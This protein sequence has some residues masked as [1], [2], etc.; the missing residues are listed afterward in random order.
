MRKTRW[1]RVIGFVAAASM[2]VFGAGSIAH[3]RSAGQPAH[4]TSITLQLKW[5]NQAQFAGY[6]V[7][8]DKGFFRQQGLDVTIR[9]GGPDVVPEQVVASGAAQF[10]I[11]WLSALL[12]AREKGIPIQNIAQ[13][14]QASGMRL[15]AFK[16]SHIRTIQDFKGKR[17][18]VWP[19]GNEYQF[20]ALMNKYHLS[21]PQHYMTVTNQPFVMTPFLSHQIDVAHA[22]T[23]NEIGVVLESGIKRSA[24][25]IFDY[26]KLGVSILEDGIFGN[27]SYLRGHRAI[28]ARFL[29]AAME[30]WRYAVAHP[31]EAGQISYRHSPGSPGGE[32]HQLF[33]AREVAKLIHYG[34]GLRHSIGYMDP[35]FY[36]RTWATLLAQ[37]VIKHPPHNAY[38]QTYW[39]L[40]GGH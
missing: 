34:P 1:F 21:P 28:A 20:Y 31:M 18:G 35:M 4:L 36:H 30:G 39:R 37:H 10:G 13:I 25:T 38:T 16:S 8:L 9:P 14:Y 12:V 32:A 29:R 2:L 27:P 3:A 7:A 22:M 17:V 5:E 40:A 6:Y 11:D 19:S 15:I 24:L 33:M 26:N 23:Y